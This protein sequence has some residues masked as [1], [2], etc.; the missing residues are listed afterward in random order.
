MPEVSVIIATYNRADLLPRAI[1]SVLD[2]TYQDFEL[3]VVDDGSTDNTREVVESFEDG[4]IRYI[5]QENQE[6]AV[7]RNTGIAASNGQ[8]ITFLDSDDCYLPGKLSLQVPVLDAHPDK[9]MVVS[10]WVEV[11][12]G[13]KILRESRPWLAASDLSAEAWLFRQLT[14]LGANLIHREWLCRVGGF[15]T[16]VVPVE[17]TYMWLQLAIVG[18]HPCWAPGL[19][20]QRHRHGGSTVSDVRRMC[21]AHAN[22]LDHVFADL[23]LRSGL[24]MSKEKAYAKMHFGCACNL[25]GAGQ[26]EEA[27]A[28]LAHAIELDPGLLQDSDGRFLNTILAWAQVAPTADPWQYLHTIFD[29]LPSSAAALAALRTKAFGGVWVVRAF[30]AYR[31]GDMTVVRRAVPRAVRRYP[32]W[33]GN[34][35]LVSIWLESWVGA[36]VMRFVRSARH[37]VRDQGSGEIAADNCRA[38]GK[39]VSCQ[40]LSV[41]QFVGS[42][43]GLDQTTSLNSQI[44]NPHTLSRII[45]T[46]IRRD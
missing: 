16:D 30:E 18:C 17:D 19:V 34:R 46:V 7:A 35:G 20:M 24:G 23:I 43:E 42:I 1:Q 4:R 10:G 8:Y 9:G 26:I 33:L 29:N 3:I 28:A 15:N 31:R 32:G 27:Q 36:K 25:Y 41:A 21:T 6:R 39:S 11:D 14:R 44:I 40:S 38:E 2:Q 45:S 5:W 12:E 22:L 13:G 37:S